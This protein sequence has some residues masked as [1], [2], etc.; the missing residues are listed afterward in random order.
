MAALVVVLD[1]PYFATTDPNGG[2]EIRNVPAG[3]YTLVAWGE[4]LK[5]LRQ[6]VSVQPE[7]PVTVTL[8]LT[9]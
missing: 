5:T 2:F 8:T 9:K 6:P 3:K 1:T 4:K 7:K